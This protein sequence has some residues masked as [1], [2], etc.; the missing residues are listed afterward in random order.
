MRCGEQ[1]HYNEE[2]AVGTRDKLVQLDFNYYASLVCIA[3]EGNSRGF[4]L[5]PLFI[6]LEMIRE[7]CC[8]VIS[9]TC[10]VPI[11]VSFIYLFY[12]PSLKMYAII[13]GIFGTYALNLPPFYRG[14]FYG[15]IIKQYV[16]IRLLPI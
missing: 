7:L 10:F 16:L 13:P 8:C 6:I 3:T 2:M 12:F 4:D 14:I 9:T 11:N 5:W 1:Y 15:K